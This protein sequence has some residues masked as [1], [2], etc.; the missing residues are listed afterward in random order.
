VSPQNAFEVLTTESDE[1]IRSIV[2][3]CEKRGFD[4][5]VLE[6]WSQ[7]VA[8]QLTSVPA[9]REAALDFVRRLATALGASTTRK[10][11]PKELLF[12]IPPAP[13]A[14]GN[15]PRASSAFAWPE[16]QEFHEL[17]GGVSLMTYDYSA[18][19]GG[20]Q[21]NA[22]LK[23]VE[24]CL[25]SLLPPGDA[26]LAAAPKVLMGLNFYGR[27]FT[28]KEMRPIVAHE[29][30]DLLEEGGSSVK[31]RWSVEHEE[32]EFEFSKNGERHVAYFPTLKSIQVRLDEARRWGAGVSI[33]EL[34][35]GFDSFF[36]LL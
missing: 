29:L 2:R 33:W 20:P 26:A 30:S 21:P 24:D 13:S 4:G 5:V 8:M 36:D 25:G 1:T 34:G 3:M 12:V 9:A 35:Q 28:P 6:A 32:H 7:W 10:G 15:A 11:Q 22:P 17:L 23:W 18:G 19:T 14:P 27:L 31:V 16:L